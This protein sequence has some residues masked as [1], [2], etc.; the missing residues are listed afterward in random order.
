MLLHKPNLAIMSKSILHV[1]SKNSVFSLAYF[2]AYAILNIIYAGMTPRAFMNHKQQAG[3]GPDH[4]L[5]I[6]I[7]ARTARCVADTRHALRR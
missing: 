1:N 3:T 7:H 5:S 6:N 4:S 2:H